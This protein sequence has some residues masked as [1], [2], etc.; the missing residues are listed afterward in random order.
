MNV[1]SAFFCL[2]IG[3]FEDEM[4]RAKRREPEDLGL[5]V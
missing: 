3:L 4:Y 1:A 5:R 2:D